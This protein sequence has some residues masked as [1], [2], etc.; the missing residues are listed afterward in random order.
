[1]IFLALV[2]VAVARLGAQNLEDTDTSDSGG[3]SSGDASESGSSSDTGDAGESPSVDIPSD[4]VLDLEDDTP[5]TAATPPKPLDKAT[6]PVAENT[7][8][9]LRQLLD[10]ALHQAPR[11][12][13]QRALDDAAEG[14]RLVAR[15]GLLPDVTAS[16]GYQQ[17]L[18][19]RL[20]NVAATKTTPAYSYWR[21]Y[22][23]A[24][25][26]YSAGLV[27]P[28]Y[29]W[30]ALRN[31]SRIG[32]LQSQI[33]QERTT[34]EYRDLVLDIRSRYLRATVLRAT[35][36]R[37]VF[38]RQLQEKK[39]TVL[40][41]RLE[42]DAA[43]RAQVRRQKLKIEQAQLAE[44]RAAEDYRRAKVQLARLVGVADIADDAIATEVQSVDFEMPALQTLA[45]AFVAD[46]PGRAANLSIIR[47]QIAIE[48]LNYRNA[49]VR[50]RPRANLSMGIT[51][52]E[53]NYGNTDYNPYGVTALYAGVS[54]NWSIF[55]G[56]A[57]KGAKLS[58]LARKRDLERVYQATLVDLSEGA[59][60]RLKSVEFAQRNMAIANRLLFATEKSLER[61]KKRVEEGR[62]SPA[63]V[64]D[65][66]L[67]V[68]DARISCYS[69][70]ADCLTQVTAL[71]STI[72]EDPAL[73][74]LDR[75]TP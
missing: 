59:R 1:L 65:A 12:L 57:T 64:D 72:F 39:A 9:A 15:S 14:N 26:G 4:A 52:E 66:Q 63:D 75:A 18:E 19:Q 69:A 53:Q 16:M 2:G 70:R 71:L 34:D 48:K 33:A 6:L 17:R 49:Q 62:T 40:Q 68:Y 46:I 13:A 47:N 20:K 31:A 25:F 73:T 58:S 22:D 54:I 67:N 50:L 5:D 60:S 45:D 42:S 23:S 32:R 37:A 30:G 3:S 36:D 51:K 74:N 41:A 21:D 24:K 7:Y 11:M 38:N 44:D 8:P 61:T 10:V 29:Y 27:Q 28:L 56:F 55:D 43:S 35:W